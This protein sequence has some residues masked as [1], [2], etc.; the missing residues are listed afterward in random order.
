MDG[1]GG[2][3]MPGARGLR[4]AVRADR[5]A[6][7]RG[8]SSQSSAPAQSFGLAASAGE[9]QVT[10]LTLAKAGSICIQPGNGLTLCGAPGLGVP[11]IPP[12]AEGQARYN[13]MAFTAERGFV[14]KVELLRIDL[15]HGQ[16]CFGGDPWTRL[17]F[18]GYY[19]CLIPGSSIVRREGAPL[20][21]SVVVSR[22]YRF[23]GSKFDGCSFYRCHR[24]SRVVA[25][26]SGEPL[27]LVEPWNAPPV[28]ALGT[29]RTCRARS[30]R[31]SKARG[32][33]PR[34]FPACSRKRL[35]RGHT[36]HRGQPWPTYQNGD[37]RCWW[38]WDGWRWV[39]RI[40]V[41]ADRSAGRRGE[42]SQS[43]AQAASLEVAASGGPA[44]DRPDGSVRGR[45]FLR[46]SFPRML[47]RYV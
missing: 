47:Q 39:L 12:A 24:F 31:I 19:E 15:Y 35:L 43:A 22:F 37:L 23:D 42:S 28:P 34:P 14:H 18:L 27:E 10:D 16:P 32:R 13:L 21:R 36:N 26:E 11:P 20:T 40:A 33:F 7:R 38:H 5:S 29:G 44:N 6:G 30:V 8:E 3:R 46:E 25:S 2:I 17:D 1:V 45:G 41:S 9:R 4:I